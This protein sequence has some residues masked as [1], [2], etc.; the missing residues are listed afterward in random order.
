MATTNL[1]RVQGGSIF[2]SSASSSTSVLKTT[3][4]PTNL[5]PLLGDIVLFSNGDI[6]NITAID[7]TTITLGSV[8]ASI[9]GLQGPQGPAGPAGATFSYD[10][11]TKTLTITTP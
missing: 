1:G 9:K 11:A 4:T 5:V 10:E 8:V 7:S 3:L 6:R 2:Y